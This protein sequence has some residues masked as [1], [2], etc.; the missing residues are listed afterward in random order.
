MRG[1]WFEK[2]RVTAIQG[3]EGT[4]G[5]EVPFHYI[6]KV[7]SRARQRIGIQQVCFLT[8]WDLTPWSFTQR[9]ASEITVSTGETTCIPAKRLLVS[10]Y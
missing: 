5:V 9:V 1:G 7:L 10:I 4:V 8:G 6:P 3:E 2:D